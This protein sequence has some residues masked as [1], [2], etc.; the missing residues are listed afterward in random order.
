MVARELLARGLD[1]FR[2]YVCENLGGRD[3]RVTQGELSEIQDMEFAPLN[4]MILRRKPGRP[5][6]PAP[7]AQAAALRQS[8]RC[9][10][11]EPAEERADHPGRGARHRAWPNWRSSPA[12]VV[13]DVGAGSGS[14]A[15]EAAQLSE[16]GMVYA[17]EQ[18]AADYHLILANAETF[19]VQQPQGDP[20]HGAGRVRGAAG[21]RCDLRRRHWPRGRPAAGSGVAGVAAGRPDGR[22]RGDAGEPDHDL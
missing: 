22:Q 18:D 20:R 4:V 7:P 16:P 9:F 3:E 8:R 14:V 12:S 6:R 10:R 21:A 15:I 5:D 17:I 2:A 19:G 1:Y 13:W 11:A